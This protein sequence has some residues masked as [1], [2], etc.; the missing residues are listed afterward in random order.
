[1]T[2]QSDKNDLV[3]KSGHTVPNVKSRQEDNQSEVIATNVSKRAMLG[4]LQVKAFPFD[5]TS[6]VLS[7]DTKT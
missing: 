5:I 6:E 2:W 3:R 7:A 4:A 1:M